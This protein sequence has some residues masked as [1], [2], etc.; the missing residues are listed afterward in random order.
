MAVE[1]IFDVFW[2]LGQV[3]IAPREPEP[4][5]ADGRDRQDEGQRRL[6]R[7]GVTLNQRQYD[8]HRDLDDG[9]GAG[10]VEQQSGLRQKNLRG[11]IIV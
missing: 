1:T 10:G 2:R 5:K 4:V 7:R 3:A 6:Q 8:D 11:V 9:A